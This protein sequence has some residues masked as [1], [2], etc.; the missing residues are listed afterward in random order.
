MFIFL[1]LNIPA[2]HGLQF[3]IGQGFLHFEHLA[4]PCLSFLSLNI[5][6]LNGLQFKTG[7]GFLHFGH[8]LQTCFS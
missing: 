8:L 7:K 2:F 6:V 3:K 5:P 1:S 4:Q